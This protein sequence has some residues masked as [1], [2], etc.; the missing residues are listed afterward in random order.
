MYSSLTHLG[1]SIQPAFPEDILPHL[2]NTDMSLPPQAEGRHRTCM[3][4]TVRRTT[5]MT[6]MTTWPASLVTRAL[7]A[8]R[9][10]K[11]WQVRARCSTESV[12]G[13]AH[14]RLEAIHRVSM[15]PLLSKGLRSVAAQPLYQHVNMLLSQAKERKSR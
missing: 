10:F 6:R 4:L 11:L 14:R 9:T 5:P 8:V 3:S 12:S 2:G 13:F 15:M 1:V 7:F